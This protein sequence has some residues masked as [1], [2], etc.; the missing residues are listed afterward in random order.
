MLAYVPDAIHSQ[1]YTHIRMRT[2]MHCRMQ[3]FNELRAGLA[4]LLQA[5]IAKQ[6]QADSTSSVKA[7]LKSGPQWDVKQQQK[8][9]SVVAEQLGFSMANGRCVTHNDSYISYSY[10]SCNS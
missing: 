3:I 4:P 1:T 5:I 7:A 9:C 8:L 2:R 6:K 10:A